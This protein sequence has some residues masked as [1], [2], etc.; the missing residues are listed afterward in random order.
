MELH[1]PEQPVS[2]R[3]S[4]QVHGKSSAVPSPWQQRV[5]S[6]S[7]E[8]RRRSRPARTRSAK[9]KTA[10]QT[11]TTTAFVFVSCFPLALFTPPSRPLAAVMITGRTEEETMR[12]HKHNSD[13]WT[14]LTPIVNARAH[15]CTTA[16]MLTGW[17]SNMVLPT[18]FLALFPGQRLQN[19][20]GSSHVALTRW[21]PKDGESDMWTHAGGLMLHRR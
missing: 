14:T 2:L 1:A 13:R 10:A 12:P 18:C 11:T 4:F 9:T 5:S 20:P 16:W 8:R 6:G 15:R 21:R 19:A 3:N 7:W 17:I